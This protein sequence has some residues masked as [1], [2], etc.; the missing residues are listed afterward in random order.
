MGD[1]ANAE[2]IAAEAEE[3][4]GGRGSKLEGNSGG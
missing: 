2:P 4:F 3:E 1:A